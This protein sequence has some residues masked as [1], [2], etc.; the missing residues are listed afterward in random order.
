MRPVLKALGSEAREAMVLRDNIFIEQILPKAVLRT[1]SVEEM[2][3]YRRPFA[4]AGDGR[5]STLT[6][7]RQI[8][9]EGEPVDVAAIAAAYA[10]ARDEQ[11]AQAIR[12]DRAWFARRRRRESR[13]RPRFAGAARGD[14]RGV[15]Y[16]QEDPPDE[17]GRAI[18]GWM[19]ALG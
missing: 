1:V 15:H 12:E 19:E 18:A 14:G 4:E 5:R 9:I 6:R 3:E 8:P 11:R 2:A 13:L 16:L 17:I 10:L 7:P